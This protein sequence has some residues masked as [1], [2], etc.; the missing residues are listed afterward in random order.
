LAFEL[1]QK[2]RL[3]ATLDNGEE[4]GIVL[5]RGS[6]LKNGDI[7]AD[8]TERMLEVVAAK[9]MVSTVSCASTTL[10]AQ[11]CY[12]LGNRHVPLQISHDHNSGKPNLWAR[13]LK[14]YVLDDMVK[15]LGGSVEHYEACF[16]PEKGAYH[17]HH[18][19]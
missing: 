16:E 2:S 7:L 10:F 15:S 5:P 13:Y 1:R 14:D 8:E 17:Q 11:L 3:K 18:H 4:I 12:H 9:E 19:A 6:V